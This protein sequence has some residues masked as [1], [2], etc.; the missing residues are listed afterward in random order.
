MRGRRPVAAPLRS[1]RASSGALW[2]DMAGGKRFGSA[3][4]RL[5]A[6]PV[7][8][9]QLQCSAFSDQS[10]ILRISFDNHVK[11]GDRAIEQALACVSRH[12]STECREIVGLQLNGTIKICDGTIE[13]A[14]GRQS[15]AA[16]VDGDVII[17]HQADRPI[18]ILYGS[19]DL[20]IR[21][22]DQTPIVV[23]SDELG[24]DPL[25]CLDYGGAT[26]D[27]T[28]RQELGSA[29]ARVPVFVA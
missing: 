27:R 12:S 26:S 10:R 19:V 15:D 23:C 1:E 9:F 14:L 24:E 3:K 4:I 18:I 13:V 21:S 5:C 8:D 7:A 2:R 6:D 25:T 28:I 17:R 29:R 16:I 20:A 11:V 22:E